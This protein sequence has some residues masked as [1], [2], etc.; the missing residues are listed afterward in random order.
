MEAKLLI[1]NILRKFTFE[2]CEKTP[3]QLEYGR[4]LASFDY[5][6]SV[7]VELRPRSGN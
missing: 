7:Y 2:V 6:E 4:C 3:K 5:K 1:F